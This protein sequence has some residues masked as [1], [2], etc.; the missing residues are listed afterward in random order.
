MRDI[1]GTWSLVKA[2]ARDEAGNILR[3]PYGPIPMG[4]II[5]TPE[6]R[7]MAVVCDGRTE[8]PADEKRGYASYCGNFRLDGNRLITTV[9]AAAIPERIGGQQIREYWFAQDF[10]VLQS[11]RRPSGEQRELFWRLSGPAH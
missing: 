1:F 2:V 7:M 3:P 4:R 5:F 6:G 10:L 11:P 8:M 9:D